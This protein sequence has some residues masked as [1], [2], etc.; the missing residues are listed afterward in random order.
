[1]IVAPEIVAVEPN[2]SLE[3][4]EPELKPAPEAKALDQPKPDADENAATAE[5]KSDCV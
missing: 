5:E 2:P 3:A 4:I 1:M